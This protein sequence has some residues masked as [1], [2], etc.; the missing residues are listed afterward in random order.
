MI[1]AGPKK[2]NGKYDFK[3]PDED[4]FIESLIYSW[5]EKIRAAYD[6]KIGRDAILSIEVEKYENPYRSRLVHIKA[7]TVAETKIRGFL[8]FKL[9]LTAEKRFLDLILNA[10]LGLYAAQGMGCVEVIE[11][12]RK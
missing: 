2:E 5:R 9:K 10:G 3:S 8:N 6:E 7:G 12:N 11:I 1:V 4:G